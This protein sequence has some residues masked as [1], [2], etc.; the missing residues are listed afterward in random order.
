M[1]LLVY[2][3]HQASYR[4]EDGGCIH[5]VQRGAECSEEGTHTESLQH[6]TQPSSLCWTVVVGATTEEA[7]RKTYDG[8]QIL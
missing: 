2:A 6:A 4:Q 8:W 1:T 5:H 7:R 3:G